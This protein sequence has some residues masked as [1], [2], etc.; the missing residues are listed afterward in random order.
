VTP[1]GIW[2]ELDGGGDLETRALKTKGQTTA[3]G[4]QVKNARPVASYDPGNFLAAKMAVVI[5]LRAI[6]PAWRIAATS[7]T[8]IGLSPRVQPMPATPFSA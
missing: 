8:D 6:L 3:A 1:R 7:P 4:K 2:L 5:Q